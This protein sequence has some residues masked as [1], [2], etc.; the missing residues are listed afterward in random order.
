MKVILVWLMTLNDVV[1]NMKIHR[2][3]SSKNI[4]VVFCDFL[5]PVFTTLH[6]FIKIAWFFVVFVNRAFLA[7]FPQFKT[8]RKCGFLNRN[9][10]TMRTS[11]KPFLFKK[12]RLLQFKRHFAVSPQMSFL[13][14]FSA[15]LFRSYR[16]KI[17]SHLDGH[18]VVK[19][20]S[21]KSENVVYRNFLWRQNKK[22]DT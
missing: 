8:W 2:L 3:A 16:R 5:S 20:L 9:T 7:N 15:A 6:S 21:L 11:S 19:V 1:L 22:A 12:V 18:S 14:P 10:P 13:T 17:I 4:S